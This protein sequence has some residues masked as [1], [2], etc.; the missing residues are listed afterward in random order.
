MPIDLVLGDVQVANALSSTDD[1]VVNQ[2][3][4]VQNNFEIAR[5]FMQ[6]HVTN[7]NFRYDMR[8]KPARFPI[9][10]WVWVGLLTYM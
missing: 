5:R 3:E 7:R 4:N 8:V 2:I 10:S 1:F 6:R 9:G